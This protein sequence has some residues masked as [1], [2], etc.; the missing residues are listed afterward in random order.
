MG[1]YPSLNT[2]RYGDVL[3]ETVSEPGL[4]RT[5]VYQLL[6]VIEERTTCFCC[7]CVDQS[8]DPSCRNHGWA[9]R[10]PCEYHQMAGDPDSEGTMPVSV[11]AY[12][13]SRGP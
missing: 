13:L 5:Y 12:R 4:K 1:I 8:S 11:E 3:Q 2:S 10:R 9:A 6:C 7:S